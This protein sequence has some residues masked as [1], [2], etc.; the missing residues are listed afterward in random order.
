MQTNCVGN[1]IMW[2]C[3]MKKKLKKLVIFVVAVGTVLL[4]AACGR[5]E[6]IDDGKIE[7]VKV[8]IVNTN[9]TSEE[10]FTMIP[11]TSFITVGKSSTP[12]IHYIPMWQNIDRM[13]VEYKYEGKTYKTD[14]EDFVLYKGK[15][16]YAKIAKEDIGKKGAS[17][18][19]YLNK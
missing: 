9:Q 16:N 14:T 6:D 5:A 10:L 2:G 15:D 1:I 18:V 17:I 7:S 12:Q 3:N 4:L 11:V 19:L 13:K 8:E